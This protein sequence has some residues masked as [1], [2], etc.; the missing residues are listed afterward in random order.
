MST[1][2]WITI[3][4]ATSRLL[5]EIAD[6]LLI[7]A[8]PETLKAGALAQFVELA[9]AQPELNLAASPG[10]TEFAVDAFLKAENLKTVRVPYK[11]LAGAARDLSEG[12]IHFLLTSYA[13]VRPFVEA[14][15][16]QDHCCG[17]P[18]AVADHQEHSFDS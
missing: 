4:N 18:A 5:R 2:S 15:K 9:R 7:V 12:R 10:L 13:V 6:T 16:V 11:E 14:G 3:S 8:V 17:Q 1:R